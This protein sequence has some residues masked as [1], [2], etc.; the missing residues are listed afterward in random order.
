MRRTALSFLIVFGAL[1]AVFFLFNFADQLHDDAADGL[2]LFSLLYATFLPLPSLMETALPIV[3]FFAVLHAFITMEHRGEI[4][5]LGTLGLSEAQILL[6]PV[7]VAVVIGVVSLAVLNPVAAA[8]T[9]KEA[10][11][12]QSG[13]L[14]L[15]ASA[16][17][18][19]FW[20][21]ENQG[22]DSE[23]LMHVQGADGDNVF[24]GITIVRTQNGQIIEHIAA[25]SAKLLTGAWALENAWRME[26]GKQAVHAARLYLPS[27][28]TPR[29]LR[30][31]LEWPEATPL[32]ALPA[33]I[34]LRNSIGAPSEIYRHRL[35]TLLAGPATLCVM[36]LLAAVFALR[37]WRRGYR[38]LWYFFTFG[39]LL[40]FYALIDIS[41]AISLNRGLPVP[42]AVWCPI[43]ICFLC[44]IAALNRREHV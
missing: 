11:L 32:A 4:I 41:R 20:L 10:T 29:V 44:S 38:A 17:D 6:A 1:A 13:D 7:A 23:V 8:L 25:P 16:H 5:P 3:V 42:F 9:R 34:K 36:V 2:S 39:S 22:G 24:H 35:H 30:Q 33:V 40:A 26:Q 28:V 14:S 27:K 19:D 18:K 15:Q 43:V 12:G 31:R 21:R 37:P